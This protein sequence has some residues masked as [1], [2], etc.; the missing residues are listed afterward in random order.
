MLNVTFGSL[1]GSKIRIVSDMDLMLWGNLPI[2]YNFFLRRINMLGLLILCSYF[3][4][5]DFASR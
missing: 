5:C 2:S 4:T 3:N 1:N